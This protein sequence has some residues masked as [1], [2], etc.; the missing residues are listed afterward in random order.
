MVTERVNDYMDSP[1]EGTISEIIEALKLE[2]QRY[3]VTHTNLRVDKV[4]EDYEDGYKFVLLGDRPATPEEIA[5]QAK[6]DAEARE[7]RK[8]WDLAQL[9]LLKAKYEIK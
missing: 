4:A 7:Q 5:I 3:S 9:E 1:L 2:E 6:E 8:K